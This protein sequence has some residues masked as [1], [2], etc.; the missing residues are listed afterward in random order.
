MNLQDN[1]DN[2][3]PKECL[4]YFKLVKSPTD[5]RINNYIV[6]V[7]VTAQ[8]LIESVETKIRWCK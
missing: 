5:T 4:T 8:K 3:I 6:N 1:S 2:I 7:P